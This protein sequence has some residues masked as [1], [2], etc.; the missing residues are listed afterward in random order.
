MSQQSIGVAVIG[1]GMA[2]RAH[3][4]GY[5]TAPTL[6]DPPLPPSLRGG[7]RRERG[8]G[9]R[10][11]RALRLRAAGT[12][13]RELL[14]AD[15]V[16]VV[17]VVVANHLH[18]EIVEGLLAAGKHVLCEKPLARLARRRRGDGGRRRSRTRPGHRRRLHLPPLAGRRRHPRN[19]SRRRS[20]SLCTS[21]ATTGATTRSTRRADHLA[22]PRRPR[23]RRAGRRRQ[24]PDRPGGVRLRAD[25]LRS[26]GAAFATLI[27][28]RPVPLGH[29]LRA[30]QGASQRRTRAGGERG[31][32][33]LHRELRQRRG[34]HVL[35]LAR[36]T[37]PRHRW[38]RAVRRDGL[39]A[40]TCT[41]R[42]SSDHPPLRDDGSAAARC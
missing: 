11:R 19:W 3:C 33:H 10:R 22:L 15:D 23:H 32:R 16:D 7:H 9:R 1:A 27:T 12:D 41:G 34:R 30:R 8:H 24:P 26:S 17:S 40:L 39:G 38:L 28:E 18:R 5:R 35:G 20:A 2:G 31:R 36:R 6:F 29:H 37:R 14:D 25:R 13:W 21:T 42:P 4:A